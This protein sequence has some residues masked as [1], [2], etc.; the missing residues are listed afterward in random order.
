M[1]RPELTQ[2]IILFGINELM[3]EYPNE[4]EGINDDYDKKKLA[5]V[6]RSYYDGYELMKEMEYAAN[7]EGHLE[8]ANTLDHL[9]IYVDS[10]YKKYL[11]QWVK[12]NNIQPPYPVGHKFKYKEKQAVITEIYSN[13]PYS[14]CVQF[15]D[16]EVAKVGSFSSSILWF[17]E[18][19]A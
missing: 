14:Y 6:Y 1:K 19:T 13:R 11:A 8:L 16:G 17:D 18:V 4:F 7:W 5:K 9:S 12:D 15:F 2:E 3:D 10:A